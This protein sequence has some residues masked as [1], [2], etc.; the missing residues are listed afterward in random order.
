MSTE[1]TNLIDSI[2]LITTARLKS[3][4]IDAAWSVLYDAEKHLQKQIAALLAE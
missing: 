1:L 3:V 4:G 2:K